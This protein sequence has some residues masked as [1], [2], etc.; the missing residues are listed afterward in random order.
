MA[1][2]Y[3]NQEF[4]SYSEF[5]KVLQEYQDSNYVLFVKGNGGTVKNANKDLPVDDPRRYPECLVYTNIVFTCKFG[6]KKRTGTGDGRRPM[7]CT[8]KVGCKAKLQLIASRSGTLKVKVFH[9]E[10]E[11]HEISKAIYDSLP[12]NRKLDKEGQE[13]AKLLFS[14]GC[15]PSVVRSLLRGTEKAKWKADDHGR[16]PEDERLIDVLSELTAED[17]GAVISVTKSESGELQF[18]F[19]Q[20]SE[21]RE[22]VAK[23][24]KV[25]LIDHTYKINKNRMPVCVLMVMDGGGSGRAA[26]YAFVANE[27]M[28]T[29][30]SVL[31]AFR[32]S[33]TE[34]LAE[35]V[36]TLIVDKDP[37]EIGAIQAVFPNAAIQL[38]SFHVSKVLNEKSRKETPEVK[39]LIKQLRSTILNSH[40]TLAESIT[41]ILELTRSKDEA[42]LFGDITENVKETCLTNDSNPDLK[43][44]LEDL[45]R[46]AAKM[47]IWEYKSDTDASEIEYYESSK[48]HLLEDYD[49]MFH[50]K[51]SLQPPSA[52]Q[53]AR[54]FV[55][56]SLPAL[57]AKTPREKFIVADQ[58][59]KEL[60]SILQISGNSGNNP[61]FA[62]RIN[63][64]KDLQKNWAAGNEVEVIPIKDLTSDVTI[65]QKKSTFGSDINS[66]AKMGGPPTDHQQ[67]V[68]CQ[69]LSLSSDENLISDNR[70]INTVVDLDDNVPTQPLSE[71]TV[72][73]TTHTDQQQ[74]VSNMTAGAGQ[75]LAH[76]PEVDFDTESTE[77]DG[78]I[79]G[80]I[81]FSDREN[82]YNFTSVDLDLNGEQSNQNSLS[83]NG[84]PNSVGD[85]DVDGGK[86][87]SDEDYD[88][89]TPIDLDLNGGPSNQNSLPVSVP[90]ND[91][92]I[93]RGN[94][95][96]QFER[97]NTDGIISSNKEKLDTSTSVGLD[98]NEVQVIHKETKWQRQSYAAQSPTPNLES[99]TNTSSGLEKNQAVVTPNCFCGIPAV[100]RTAR[101]SPNKQFFGCSRY[102]SSEQK[103]C[104]FHRFTK[105]LQSATP[106][107]KELLHGVKPPTAVK[108]KG[109]PHQE[110]KT[111]QIKLSQGSSDKVS[112][113]KPAGA[114]TTPFQMRQVAGE[115]I[116]NNDVTDNGNNSYTI[117]SQTNGN[118]MYTVTKDSCDCPDSAQLCKHIYKVRQLLRGKATDS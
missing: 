64:L 74:T 1:L 56:T 16:T 22:N 65:S 28:T 95:I 82:N 11:N 29:V 61:Q 108:T 107:V 37:S 98:L 49:K 51:N 78:E 42:V 26:G 39:S 97:V 76:T 94:L 23:Y 105:A 58:V 68:V 109:R 101:N 31:E 75:L 50:K 96:T 86:I 106:S 91:I 81:I 15:K 8:Y 25:I 115:Q 12:E 30:H 67:T 93:Q 13:K 63:V 52:P 103:H 34:E 10:H 38:C 66:A 2:L 44:M 111:C 100:R 20:T 89:P 70:P 7:Q 9:D 69:T 14:G 102:F 41:K 36:R 110:H 54:K 85:V 79:D 5:E 48:I 24:G 62:Q 33:I 45:T 77:I 112:I 4:K 99:Q 83:V 104:G 72:M 73:C 32:E 17:P 53:P 117:R 46:Y 59:T 35:K 47:Q 88:S 80:G 3:E 21:M 43:C 27:K 118:S 90:S 6:G 60:V 113:K 71:K 84:P 18:I 19:L 87:S 40:S 55:L 114:Y 57:K 116:S 92:G